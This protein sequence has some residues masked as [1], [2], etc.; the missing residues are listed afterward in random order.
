MHPSLGHPSHAESLS[1]CEMLHVPST[2]NPHPPPK[3]YLGVYLSSTKMDG[4][5][6]HCKDNVS[7]QAAGIIEGSPADE[8]GLKKDD[9]ILSVNGIPTCG[10]QDNIFTSF[11]KM[12]EHQE[13]GSISTMDV[14][15]GGHRLSLTARLKEAP[16]HRQQEALHPDIGVCNA[17]SL[18]ENTLRDRGGLTVF[19]SVIDGLYQRSNTVHNPGWS[20]E[21][22]SNPLQLTELTY[23]MRHPLAAGAVA[24][25]LS[26]Q[27]VAPLHERNWRLDETIRRAAGLLDLDLPRFE[28]PGEITFPRLLQIMEA[29]K[30]RVEQVLSRLTLEDRTLLEEKALRPWDDDKWNEV[31]DISMKLDRRELLAAFS[32]LLSFLTRD[33]LSLLREDL[34]KRFGRN[35]GP[36]L[37][38]AV[39]PIGKVIVG[40]PGPNVYTEDAALILDLGGD[41]LYLNNAG[42]T[43]PGM[44]VALVIDWEGNDRYI[45]K[46]NFS[47]GA[48]LLGGGFL[49]DLSGNDTF[50]SLDGSQGAGFFGIGLLY[51][52]SGDS[53][54]NARSFSQGTGQM[55]M[56]LIMNGTGNDHYLCSHHGQGLGLFG[57]AGILIDE[58]GD[59]Y[60]QLGGSEPDFRDPLKSTVSMGQG[61]G[62][63]VRPDKGTHGVPGGIG[64]LIDER[65][66]DVYIADYFAQGSS[67]YYGIGILN[68]MAGNDR[69]ISG[70][71]SQGAGIHSSVGVLVDQEGDDFYY[72]S[73]GVAQGM[74][75]DYGV[76]FFEDDHGDDTYWGG[77][78]VQGATTGGGIG[79]FIDR[80]GKDRYWHLDKGQGFA[81]EAGSV[82]IMM[83]KEPPDGLKSPY[84][85]K[86]SVRL[87]LRPSDQ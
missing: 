11:K 79:V 57:G 27:L 52:G 22:E 68:D 49:I 38:E 40:G 33:N 70:R 84:D 50:V 48:G 30:K 24:K 73:F 36:I 31:L 66:N 77:T 8:A 23:L 28:D 64:M 67:Y 32:P 21:K 81:A 16:V 47:Q 65:G 42:G 86:R 39:T 14:M 13:I 82:A 59:D 41:D 15:R 10:D 60:Y 45:T 55:G 71:Y 20:Y 80:E 51:H 35:S 46:E 85:G 69:Y 61:F 53:V 2:P 74:G 3:P 83:T 29:A 62:L 76:G 43:R 54:Y 58:A 4:P 26:Q 75:H 34:I 56:G 44:P 87:G 6:V 25:E 37:F 17:T 18:I 5:S 9:I 7:V 63:G 1:Y 72:A 78:L 19:E 12:I